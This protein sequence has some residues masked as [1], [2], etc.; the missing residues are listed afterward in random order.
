ME[1]AP[2]PVFCRSKPT[3]A[4]LGD[5]STPPSNK[6]PSEEAKPEHTGAPTS[7]RSDTERLKELLDLEAEA[8]TSVHVSLFVKNLNFNTSEETLTDLFSSSSGFVKVLF[9]S[10]HRKPVTLFRLL[11]FA[12]DDYEKKPGS[13]AECKVVAS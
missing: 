9:Q 13:E 12:G 3:V 10:A 8:D 2:K 7:S 5:S 4:I 6:D 11:L 1:W